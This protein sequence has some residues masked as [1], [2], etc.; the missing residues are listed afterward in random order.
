MSSDDDFVSA[1]RSASSK[2]PTSATK[3]KLNSLQKKRMKGKPTKLAPDELIE[4]EASTSSSDMEVTSDEEDAYEEIERTRG[5][6]VKLPKEEKESEEKKRF[7]DFFILNALLGLNE[8]CLDDLLP[9][10]DAMA[11]VS[12]SSRLIQQ[13][14][15]EI[16]ALFENSGMKEYESVKEFI[17]VVRISI[18][19]RVSDPE[20][21]DEI[22]ECFITQKEIEAN[23]AK[24][25]ELGEDELQNGLKERLKDK[26]DGPVSINEKKRR[27]FVRSGVVPLLRSIFFVLKMD[28]LIQ[29]EIWR[30]TTNN[31]HALPK[32]LDIMQILNLFTI[33]NP[34]A[35]DKYFEQYEESMQFIDKYKPNPN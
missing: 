20:K 23:R 21:D 24:K 14:V 13:E 12:A 30:W 10:D 34:E 8:N 4:N 2:A 28:R 15:D 16:I 5:I 1:F 25:I 17:S 11:K 9:D 27:I 26:K 22:G 32:D 7:K 29:S 31:E 35:I 19:M 3:K 18:N 33:G 6:S